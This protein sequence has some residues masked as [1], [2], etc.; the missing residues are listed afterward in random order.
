MKRF[1]STI[2]A[3]MMVMLTLPI[4]SA[5]A[6]DTSPILRDPLRIKELSPKAAL[7]SGR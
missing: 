5:N 4:F 1:I 2:L 7:T 3:I 6:A